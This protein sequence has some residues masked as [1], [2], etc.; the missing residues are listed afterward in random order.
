MNLV[1]R[2]FTYK[3]VF[4]IFSLPLFFREKRRLHLFFLF[5]VR[6]PF[7]L[8]TS[9]YISHMSYDLLLFLKFYFDDQMINSRMRQETSRTKAKMS[10]THSSLT[11]PVSSCVHLRDLKGFHD[12]SSSILVSAKRQK[13]DKN[14]RNLSWN[15][16][17]V[18]L[19]LGS[20]HGPKLNLH[21]KTFFHH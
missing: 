20:G 5:M 18:F 17:N 10:L 15:I 2:W 11:I 9:T 3:S 1:S 6:N 16:L 4:N 21:H 7:T 19:K 8:L 12:I 13:G 14:K